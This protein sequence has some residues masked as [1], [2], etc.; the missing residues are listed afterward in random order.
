M[1]TRSD[2]LKTRRVFLSRGWMVGSEILVKS[3][4]PE[5]SGMQWG[6]FVSLFNL[7]CY[8]DQFEVNTAL[9]ACRNHVKWKKLNSA[10]ISCEINKTSPMEC[11]KLLK[12]VY[13]DNLMARSR[14]LNCT[15]DLMRVVKKWKMIN[16]QITLRLRKATKNSENHWNCLQRSTSECENDCRH[17]GY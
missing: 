11:I 8:W 16:I 2:N 17:C 6:S 13:G 9:L 12:G 1:S 15:K 5:V 10:E 3:V 4:D 7:V 14:V